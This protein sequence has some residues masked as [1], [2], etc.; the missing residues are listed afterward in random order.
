M[1]GISLF[2]FLPRPRLTSALARDVDMCP[3]AALAFRTSLFLG[4]A[5]RLA[6]SGGREGVR[7]EASERRRVAWR[8]VP[9]VLA[10]RSAK[11]RQSRKLEKREDVREM[12][13]MM[14]EREA[15]AAAAAAYRPEP[16]PPPADA[17]EAAQRILERQDAFR[18][19]L[20]AIAVAKQ[21]AKDSGSFD[22][23][24]G[25]KP[26]KEV[27]DAV[28]AMALA[29]IAVYEAHLERAVALLTQ[30]KGEPPA[31]LEM[32]NWV[33]EKGV[34]ESNIRC[35]AFMLG[36]LQKNKV[37]PGVSEVL[38]VALENEALADMD[39]KAVKGAVNMLGD[40]DDL[41]LL[42][43]SEVEILAATRQAMAEAKAAQG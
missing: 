42:D 25:F 2:A 40:L 11:K 38:W 21:A 23:S 43:E 4:A 31:T 24:R 26:F 16:P 29:K 19:A 5:T 9:R 37:P 13:K 36:A 12:Q 41:G 17:A 6:G 8:T 35:L 33:Y 14:E 3:N 22:P 30:A 28:S 27:Q 15:K 18:E 34:V 39:P 10:K 32:F 20:E 1:D 7:S